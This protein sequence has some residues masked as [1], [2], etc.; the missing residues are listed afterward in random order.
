MLSYFGSRERSVADWEEIFK[1]AD[2]RFELG[3]WVELFDRGIVEGGIGDAI[4]LKEAV[5][6]GYGGW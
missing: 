5:V 4:Y 3:K 6:G 1:E 2:E